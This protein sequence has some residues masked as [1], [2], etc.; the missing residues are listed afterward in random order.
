M[1]CTV[2][3]LPLYSDL[4]EVVS[5]AGELALFFKKNLLY[6]MSICPIRMFFIH[7]EY[8]YYTDIHTLGTWCVYEVV[9]SVS[10][11]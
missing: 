1:Y 9:G 2:L 4:C 6:Q 5:M 10:L 11:C 8:I 7:I 3:S